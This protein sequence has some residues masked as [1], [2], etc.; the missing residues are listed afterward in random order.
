M[1]RYLTVRPWWE[2]LTLASVMALTAWGIPGQISSAA[3]ADAVP[4]ELNGPIVQIGPDHGGA[5]QVSELPT[6]PR[7]DQADSQAQADAPPRLWLGVRGGPVADPVLRTH[8]QLAADTGVVIEEVLP[9]SPAAKAGLRRHDIILRANGKAVHGMEVLQQAVAESEGRPIEL[10]LI[11]LGQE[12]TLAATPEER[13]ADLSGQSRPPAEG[14]WGAGFGGDF[15]GGLGEG[16]G[17]RFGRGFAGGGVAQELQ[18][19]LRQFQ[20]GGGRMRRIGPGM[21]LGGP[22]GAALP[23]GV[24]VRVERRNDEPPTITLQ[25]GDETWTASADDPQS[26]EKFPEELRPF[27]AQMLHQLENGRAAAAGHGWGGRL[28][29]DQLE[30]MQDLLPDWTGNLPGLGGERAEQLRQQ[31]ERA[32]EEA[33]ERAEQVQERLQKRMEAMEE[34][35]QQL[36]QQLQQKLPPANPPAAEPDADRA[37]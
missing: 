23:N 29:W 3:E 22:L 7:A 31:A 4:D 8:L 15:G 16:F 37:T 13:P 2:G 17:E 36:Q 33:R 24:S 18:D 12:M 5:N 30:G 28:E 11:R 32:R 10:T 19:M 20:E 34:R 26:L 35:L 21:I 14:N 25:R 9:E 1:T 27:A 6:D